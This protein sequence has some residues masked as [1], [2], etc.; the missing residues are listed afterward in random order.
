M[1]VVLAFLISLCFA[2]SQNS[3]EKEVNNFQDFLYEEVTEISP[4]EDLEE[5][6]DKEVEEPLS[7]IEKIYK[8]LYP[9]DQL[10]QFGYDVFEKKEIIVSVPVGDS[11]ILGPGDELVIYFWGDPVEV[12][13][14]DSFYRVQI[15]REGKVFIPSVGVMYLWGK[16]V[17]DFREELKKKLSR[18]FKR[19]SIEVSLGKLRKFPVY[20]SGFV[21]KPGIVTATVTDSV[22]DILAS[23]GGV[24]KSGSLRNIVI[25]KNSGEEIKV[26]LY[27]FLIKG[28]KINIK[29]TDGDVI[30]VPPIGETVGV[31]GAVKR[32]AIYEVK[33]EK[34]LKEVLSLAGGI[35]PSA[36]LPLIKI[37]RYENGKI[38]VRE[39]S[40]EYHIKDGD[41]IILEG[42]YT[43]KPQEGI[44][45]EGFVAYPGFYSLEETKTLKDLVFKVKLLPDTNMYYGEILRRTPPDYSLKILRF[46]PLDVVKGKTNLELKNYD[47][48]RFFPRWVFPPIYL[49]GEVENPTVIP[50]YEGITLLDV[51]REKKFTQEI[52]K[53][54]VDI[55]RIT[56]TVEETEEK[57]TEEIKIL[58]TVYLSELLVEGKNNLALMPGD[59]VVVKKT[60]PVEKDKTVT[61]L[62]E[63]VK[64]GIYKL[65][66]GMTLYDLLLKAGGYTTRAY[67]K[68]IVFVRESAKKLQEEH[69]KIALSVLEESLIKGEEG[70]ELTGASAEERRAL[71]ITLRKQKRLYELI[72]H[73]AQIGLGRIALDI[74]ETLEE[75]KKSKDNIILEAG[76]YIYIPSRPN[77]I[78]VLGDVYNQISLPFRKGATLSYYLN[79]VGGPATNAD[80]EN[81]YVIKA[82]GRVISRRNYR[83]TLA[84][85]WKDNKLYFAKDFM[86]LPLEEG[87]TVVV[88][89][90]L[91]V[92]TMWR[93]LIRDVVQIIFQAISTAVLAKR[94]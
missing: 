92:P 47:I 13:N 19:F 53:L 41:L 2:L 29:I 33:E 79:Q 80:L 9:E 77:Y 88:P 85:N 45:V 1:F 86:D 11:Y 75:L 54:R 76:D 3:E 91:K 94:L 14:L 74:P 59:R 26:D 83:K 48:V 49:S 58:T 46:V 30:Y 37:K 32:S 73:K 64:P 27:D 25:R 35:L 24:L 81:I 65:E 39:G 69:L 22:I 55:Y 42:A 12:L 63:V 31:V 56:K 84:F 36:Y 67:P 71:E 68:G 51:L 4:E 7:P 82:N 16:S 66:K 5:E 90:K 40:F 20:V 60:S 62:G 50:F 8:D 61:V 15:D 72:K 44:H 21:K 87:D 57:E 52:N 43:G 18:K 34:K 70:L 10:R 17:S 38:S 93:P 89:S 6:T 78:L 28:K 23:A